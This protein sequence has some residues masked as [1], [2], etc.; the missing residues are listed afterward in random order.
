[1]ITGVTTGDVDL[2][3][4]PWQK[5]GEVVRYGLG[6]PF[7]VAPRI[8]ALIVDA[9][10]EQTPI[11]GFQN[12]S[13]VILFDDLDTISADKAVP[14]RRNAYSID[15]ATGGNFI[16]LQ[17]S[18]IAGFVP[19]GARGDDGSAHPHA[20]TGFGLGQ[21]HRMPAD[22]SGGFAWR[23]EKRR[24][25]LEVFQF[26]FDG[27]IFC[28]RK[29]DEGTQDS[30]SP[31]RIGE[32]GW[33][34]ISHGLTS[35]I[36]DG[37]DLLLTVLARKGDVP[38]CGVARWSRQD[39]F[40]RPISFQSVVGEESVTSQANYAENCQW[41]EPSLIRDIDGSLLFSARGQDSGRSRE[42]VE[43]G[44]L[45]RIWRSTDG[46]SRWDVVVDGPGV[47]QFAPVTIN[48]APDGTPYV[49]STPFDLAFV[50][51]MSLDADVATVRKRGRG[52]EILSVWPLNEERTG[53]LSPMI[54]RDAEAE[55][56][57]RPSHP[58]WYDG[59][60]VDHA[61]ASTVRL[62]D[63]A[64]HNVLVYRCLHSALYH[65]LGRYPASQTGCYLEEVMS[66]GEARGMWNFGESSGDESRMTSQ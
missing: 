39:G 23:D 35:A 41:M 12:G 32:S 17:S 62:A 13:D 29:S 40:W 63:G 61:S 59:W 37:D 66:Q 6:F 3:A 60:M 50:F 16:H 53:L 8:A 5:E 56:G 9:H 58:E 14:I 36:P 19:L 57:K 20:G 55:F 1:M 31:L 28:S 64:W 54:I 26:S 18:V 27:R 48:Q 7:Q 24:D 25:L 46:G 51:K 52:R 43:L 10:I 44:K 34:I 30:S 47:R 11:Y 49:V 38:A 15:A 22:E 21:A 42:N 65:S 4:P 45:I 2:T 33:S